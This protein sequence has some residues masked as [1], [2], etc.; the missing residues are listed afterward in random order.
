MK[1][2]KRLTIHM[3]GEFSIENESNRF[4]KDQKKSM[5]IIILIAYLIIHRHTTVSKTKLMEVLWS[6]NSIENPEGALRNLIYR[7]RKELEEFFPGDKKVKC[8]LSKGSAYAWNSDVPQLID[9]EDME[10]LGERILEE[11]NLED[12]RRYALQLCLYYKLDFMQEFASE[13]WVVEKNESYQDMVLGILD[14][15][16]SA[17]MNEEKYEYVIELCSYID[18]KNFYNSNIHEYKLQSY[19]NLNQI[20]PALTYY[21]KVVNQYYSTLGVQPTETMI[22]I[23]EKLLAKTVEKSVT[24]SDLE[25]R[26]SE[27]HTNTGAF[28]CDF[29]MFRNIYNINQRSIRR[30][31]SYRFLVLLTLNYDEE[32]MKECE[33]LK[34]MDILHNII[35]K[36]LRKND[37]FSKCNENQYA[38]I[39]MTKDANGCMNAMDRV[40]S[41]FEMDKKHKEVSVS[42][43][44][45]EIK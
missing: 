30:T 41:K 1:K 39:V 26:L 7:A 36:Y 22:S 14:K 34:D 27:G 9:I 4:P 37:I 40:V 5:Q 44:I 13:A 38:I 28:Y 31:T 3:L 45:Q 29:D 33:Y 8:I 10:V 16:C 11:K 43:D 32:R 24:V 19:Y 35:D 2:K 42:F 23:Y 15:T 25:R 12:M 21:H 18:F 6:K 20:A 17:F